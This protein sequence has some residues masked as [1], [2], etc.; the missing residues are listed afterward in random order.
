MV[1]VTRV[2]V[3][4]GHVGI[5]TGEVG[6]WVDRLTFGGVVIGIGQVG[7]GIHGVIV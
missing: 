7:Q 1:C 2:S 3:N 4:G 6:E 5:H